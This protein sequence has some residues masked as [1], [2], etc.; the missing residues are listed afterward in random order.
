MP[1]QLIRSVRDRVEN[2]RLDEATASRRIEKA[3]ESLVDRLEDNGKLALQDAADARSYL[4]QVD[5]AAMVRFAF[6]TRKAIR[7][8]VEPEPERVGRLDDLVERGRLSRAEAQERLEAAVERRIDR[9]ED[10]GR[11]DADEA[12]TLR[13]AL[14]RVRDAGDVLADMRGFREAALL[15]ERFRPKDLYDELNEL[16]SRREDGDLPR[17]FAVILVPPPTEPDEFTF[18]FI[19]PPPPQP[20]E[21]EPIDLLPPPIGVELEPPET[22]PRF[23]GVVFPPTVARPEMPTADD[24][25]LF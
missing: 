11:L 20:I 21:F 19:S 2:G 24:G 8:A 14:G 10:R 16:W 9:M 4:S 17:I 5:D 7:E 22:P 13:E 15:G 1:F 6:Q 25:F 12:Q 23:D 3:L 18:R